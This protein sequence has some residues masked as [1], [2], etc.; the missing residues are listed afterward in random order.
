MNFRLIRRSASNARYGE[1]DKTPRSP[2][3]LN[4]GETVRIG[5]GFFSGYYALVQEFVA[6]RSH[7]LPASGQ[8]WR[9]NILGELIALELALLVAALIAIRWAS[10]TL[11]AFN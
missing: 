5:E 4:I 9:L 7:R 6:K 3:P 1:F 11:D 10:G 2:Q 8:R